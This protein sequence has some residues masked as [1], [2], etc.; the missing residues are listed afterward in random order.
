MI[1]FHFIKTRVSVTYTISCWDFSLKSMDSIL[2]IVKSFHAFTVS[3]FHRSKRCETVKRW[4]VPILTNLN[5]KMKSFHWKVF[6]ESVKTLCLECPLVSL[7]LIFWIFVSNWFRLN[8]ME[9]F[10]KIDKT[11]IFDLQSHIHH[12]KNRL[13]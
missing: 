4:K 7:I 10:R 6:T 5:I 11:E 8:E 3:P 9:T 1:I 2:N 13:N 12:T